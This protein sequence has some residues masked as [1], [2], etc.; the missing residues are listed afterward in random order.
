MWLNLWLHAAAQCVKFQIWGIFQTFPN[1]YSNNSR[2]VFKDGQSRKCYDMAYVSIFPQP[3]EVFTLEGTQCNFCDGV[4]LN[5]NECCAQILSDFCRWVSDSVSLTFVTISL[6]LCLWN[7]AGYCAAQTSKSWNCGVGRSRLTQCWLEY[8]SWFSHTA[9]LTKLYSAKNNS[10]LYVTARKI[11]HVVHA[12]LPASR[13]SYGSCSLQHITLVL[14]R[15]CMH[16]A[17]LTCTG[18]CYIHMR[19]K[20]NKSDTHAWA[21]YC[22]VRFT[23]STVMF[24]RYRCIRRHAP[25]AVQHPAGCS[26][27]E[28]SWGRLTSIQHQSR[29]IRWCIIYH[30]PQSRSS[31]SSCLQM[32]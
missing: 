8:V 5:S 11:W 17:L 7:S 31:T 22:F 18:G 32:Q 13:V 24:L 4:N 14:S 1:W 20:Y 12:N 28:I 16:N 3:L 21:C 26:R 15:M 9:S 25:A 30:F 2:G 6:S 23:A 27:C 19:A 10:L 29:D